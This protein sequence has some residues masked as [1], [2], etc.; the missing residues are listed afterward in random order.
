MRNKLVFATFG[1]AMAFVGFGCSSTPPVTFDSIV[2]DSTLTKFEG[3]WVHPNPD[4]HNSTITFSGNS[5]AKKG[6]DYVINGRFIDD[7]KKIT[8]YSDNGQK[9]STTYKIYETGQ[10]GLFSAPNGWGWS[11][12]FWKIDQNQDLKLDGT[13]KL[14]QSVRFDSNWNLVFSDAKGATF[15]FTG[16]KFTYTRNDGVEEIGD[17]ELK[18]NILTL[19]K[20]GGNVA[21]YVCYLTENSSGLALAAFISGDMKTYYWGTYK[22]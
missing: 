20:S 10:L 1:L 2:A 15:V 11:G 13:W 21:E 3:I 12:T 5:F 16:N 6:D 8:M 4:S 18:G 17:Y 22:K 9:W 7:G 14:G 19:K